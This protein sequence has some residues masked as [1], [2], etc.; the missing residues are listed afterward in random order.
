SWCRGGDHRRNVDLIS[1]L[2]NAILQHILIYVPTQLAISTSVLSRR[3][4]H[5]WSD[6][7]SLSFD[8]DT[9]TYRRRVVH[10][11]WINETLTRYTAPKMIKFHLKTN[12]INPTAADV[13]RWIQFSMHRSVENLSLSFGFVDGYKIPDFFYIN[14][15][16]KQLSFQ[17]LCVNMIPR[18]CSVSWTS[19]EKLSLRNCIL[20]DESIAM[21]LCG[22]PILESLALFD[23]H[24]LKVLD[25][26]KSLRLTTL[27]VINDIRFRV[28]EPSHIVAP[29]IHHLRLRYYKSP[30]FVDVSS[31]TEANVDVSVHSLQEIL[32]SDFLQAILKMLE[33]LQ[34]AYF[35][36]LSIAEVC[37]VTFPMLKIKALTLETEIYQYAIPGIQRLLQNSLGLKMVTVHARGLYKSVD[38]EYDNY[39]DLQDFN[40]DQRWKPKDGVFWN[41]FSSGL[42]TKLVAS[43]VELVLK[44]AMTI[45]KMVPQFYRSYHNFKFEELVQTL[46]QNNTVS[47]IVLST[48]HNG[49]LII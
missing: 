36:L 40:L 19:L 17:I 14:S 47:I 39:L 8:D 28:P 32:E 3:W 20:S 6:T 4:R 37:G 12:M 1:S 44:N 42:D 35:W 26:S 18:R 30:I 25:L 10:A 46:P 49:T 13:D 16:I 23:C 34:N 9:G 41:R 45:D 7:P 48:M 24:K 43:F 31:L 11:A 21:I 38:S 15:S 33:K 29:H 22:C 27:E 5:V 2:P